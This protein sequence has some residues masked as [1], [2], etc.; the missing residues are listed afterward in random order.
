M[1]IIIQT[2]NLTK[3]Y[4]EQVSVH[5]LN[6]TVKK[7]EIYGFLGRNGA[8][9]TTT[10]K[11]LLGLTKPSEGEV[12]LF[13]ET[14]PQNKKRLLTRIGA[15]VEIPG[16]YENLT[17]RENLLINARIMGIHKKR[18]V[19]EALEIVGLEKETKKLV[20]KYSLGMKQRLGIARALLHEP[21]LLILDE[22]TNGLDPIGIK[23]MRKL[24]TSLAQERDIT[25]LIS[26]HILFEVEQLAHRIGI[27]HKGELLEEL[28]MEKLHTLNKKHI[29]F[30]VSDES[31][32]AYILEE[33]LGISHYQVHEDRRIR[34]YSHLHEQHLINKE[35]VLGN[36]DVYQMKLSEDHLEDY[37]IN[38]VG[39]GTIG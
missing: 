38:L 34:V 11:M 23:E 32:A 15:I 1:S 24:I 12:E 8:G 20:G 10:I 14:L 35:L 21:E 4:G 25:I 27:I 7:G 31:K 37:F 17:A 33:K 36:V 19:E 5:R 26:S 13:G 28:D 22:P 30:Y 16:F 9:K 39:G 18:A 2:T 29:E 6:M 3:K